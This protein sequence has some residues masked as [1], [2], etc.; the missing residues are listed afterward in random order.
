M[1][2]DYENSD[3][4]RF[5]CILR[6]IGLKASHDIHAEYT[7]RQSIIHGRHRE[8]PMP[9]LPPPP[10]RRDMLRVGVLGTAGLA[11]PDLL[12]AS[13]TRQTQ[14]QPLADSCILIFCW[15]APSQYETFDPKPEAPDGIRGEFGT[16]RTRL[17]SVLFGEYI[18]MLAERNDRFSIIRTC[19]Q[20]STHHQSAAYAA[21]TG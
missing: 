20:S 17:P 1:A 14:G 3:G 15:G 13:E 19:A 8:E 9:R 7:D 10:S 6:E 2:P 16:R 4:N 18:P 21:L 12:R 5:P 11:L